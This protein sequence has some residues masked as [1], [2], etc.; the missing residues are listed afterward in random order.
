[1]IDLPESAD[2]VYFVYLFGD[3]LYTEVDKTLY[4]FFLSDL[5]CPSATY[6]LGGNEKGYSALIT[7]N[8]LYVGGSSNLHIFEVT[9]SL[10]EP[11]I[12]VTKIPTNSLVFKI[13]RVGDELILG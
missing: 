5:T 2:K 13:L 10:N 6:K 12:P 3:R 4:V 8:H 11:L 9:S 7:E 1:M